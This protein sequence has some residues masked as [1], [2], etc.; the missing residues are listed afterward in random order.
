[1]KG[2]FAKI[3]AWLLL[4]C[5][6]AGLGVVA[7]FAWSD[8]RDL[9]PSVVGAAAAFFLAPAFHEWG[10]V[11]FATANSLQTVYCKFFCF[12]FYRKD[13]KCRFGF[14]NPFAPDETQVLPM[15]SEDMKQRA[16][17]YAVG[18]LAVEGVFLLVLI[19]ACVVCW[20]LGV[21]A[22]IAVAML[23]Y[24]AYHFLLNLMP[25]EY[26]SG[27]TDAL[28][29]SGLKKGAPAEETMLNI[30]R[31]HGELQAGKTYAEMDES[32]Y[33]SAPQLAEDEPLYVAILDARYCY[34]LEKEEYEKA[35]DCLKRIRSAGEYLSEQEILTL[36]RNL[37]Y[38]CLVGGNDEVLKTAVKNSEE[39][40]KSEDAS[41]KRTLALYMQK[42]GE[43]DRAQALIEQAKALLEKESIVG[44]RRH[45]ELL[46]FR[47]TKEDDK[48]V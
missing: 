6:L 7:A 22:Y 44:I 47:I 20:C 34:Y 41:I 29:A 18:G 37:A 43:T 23:P 24:T 1:M 2:I 12:R 33:F 40:W 27:K 39:Y 13:G 19:T 17:A 46:L 9:I 48:A 21:A 31:I 15:G 32:W 35:F 3:Y 16:Y 25:V 11:I 45:E 14:A 26:P 38:L 4:V 28:V 10:H 5:M 30:M 36:E 42:C 8:V